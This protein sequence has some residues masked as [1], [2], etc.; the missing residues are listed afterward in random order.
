MQTIKQLVSLQE[1]DLALDADRRK[2]EANKGAMAVPAA[3]KTLQKKVE[4]ANVTVAQL[5]K[6]RRQQ[7]EAV[8]ELTAK[9]KT[10][11][12]T[13]YGGSVKEPREQVA[14]QQNIESLKRH[15]A[16]LE[17]EALEIMAA[18]EGA[19]TEQKALQETFKKEVTA[20][21]EKRVHL[22]E[23][24]EQL[25]KHARTLK[26]RREKLIAAIP[27]PEFV[28][29]ETLRKKTGG[30]A[31]AKLNGKSCGACGASLPTTIVQKARSGQLIT[32]PL[33]GRLLHN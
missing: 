17:E 8:A 13:L 9:I 24:Q 33:C 7:D 5:Q 21:K 26:V 14:L 19:E 32:C 25:V 31:I 22:E 4:K 29:Y 3:L 1:L 11:E 20:F 30:V 15:L 10:Q 28:R 16:K 2:F 23:A 27:Q 12:E 18:L 6:E